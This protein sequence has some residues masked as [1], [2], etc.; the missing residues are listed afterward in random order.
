MNTAATWLW[1]CINPTWAGCGI[2]QFNDYV[3]PEACSVALSQLVVAGNAKLAA[4]G[5]GKQVVA[6]CKPNPNKFESR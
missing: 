1:I 2:V 6:Y 4:G 3:T 5:D